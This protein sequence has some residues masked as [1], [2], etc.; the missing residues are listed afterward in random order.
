ML[1]NTA[2]LTLV[3][4]AL[5][6]MNAA[7]ADHF[8]IDPVHSVAVFRIN[9]AGFSYT[10]GLAPN[11]EGEFT[12]D[13]ADPAACSISVTAPALDIS[14]E[15]AER[16]EK[17]LGEDLLN[18]VDFRTIQFK[19]TAC[20]EVEKGKYEIIG[21]LTLLAVTKPITVQA[22]FVGM[23]PGYD[24]EVRC[25]FDAKFTIKRSDFGI[26]AGLPAIGDEVQLTIG[27]EGVRD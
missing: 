14:T 19:S 4:L 6:G 2:A 17:I 15:H 25:G 24:N 1:K 21:D 9:H 10:Y 7:A 16:D 20:K 5:A 13:P 8:K 27:I 3:L 22:E 23:G 11:L 18:G 12:F 26:T